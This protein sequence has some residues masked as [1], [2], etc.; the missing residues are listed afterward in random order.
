[1]RDHENNEKLEI[2]QENNESYENH[3]IPH[4]NYENHEARITKIKKI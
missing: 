3:R 1:M 4:E 2:S